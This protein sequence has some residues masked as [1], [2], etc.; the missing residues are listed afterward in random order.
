MP[1]F[2]SWRVLGPCEVSCQFRRQSLRWCLDNYEAP[3]EKEVV[4]AYVVNTNNKRRDTSYAYPATSNEES[5]WSNSATAFFL[6]TQYEYPCFPPDALLFANWW[7]LLLPIIPHRNQERTRLLSTSICDCAID[8]SSGSCNQENLLE[9]KKTHKMFLAKSVSS[10]C[11]FYI[12][13]EEGDAPDLYIEYEYLHTI[14]VKN[15][16]QAFSWGQKYETF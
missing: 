8:P 2:I 5:F 12:H 3:E 6:R 14:A 16:A 11:E 1:Y 7:K 10:K 9:I 13:L 15:S 4:N